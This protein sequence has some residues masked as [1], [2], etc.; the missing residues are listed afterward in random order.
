MKKPSQLWFGLKLAQRFET[1]K[2]KGRT[3]PGAAL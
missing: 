3:V 1:K 2:Q